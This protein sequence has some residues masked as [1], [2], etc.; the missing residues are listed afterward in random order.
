MY[1]LINHNRIQIVVFE[2]LSTPVVIPDGCDT[3]EVFPITTL[4]FGHEIQSQVTQV[5]YE[6]VNNSSRKLVT[7]VRK[8]K[9]CVSATFFANV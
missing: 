7:G 2:K 6:L 4:L 9:I 1:S 5:S 3:I 8:V